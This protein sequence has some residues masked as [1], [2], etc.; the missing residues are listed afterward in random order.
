M[1]VIV[2]NHIAVY[3]PGLSR[4]SHT[5][6][7]DLLWSWERGLVATEEIHVVG[8]NGEPHGHRGTMTI[9]TIF[10]YILGFM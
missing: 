1:N 9:E 3:E 4:A 10:T 2:L 6:R 7:K 5:H 8:G